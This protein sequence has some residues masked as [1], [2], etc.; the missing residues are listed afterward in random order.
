LPPEYRQLEGQKLA[1]QLQDDLQ[2]QK[3]EKGSHAKPTGENILDK[4]HS[5][6][7]HNDGPTHRA[8]PV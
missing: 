3:A 4:V 6:I 5:N 2:P 1:L 8:Q 7:D